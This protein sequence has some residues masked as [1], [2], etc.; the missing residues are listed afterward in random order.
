MEILAWSVTWSELGNTLIT[1]S[2]LG[3]FAT[4]LRIKQ[5]NLEASN[6][7]NSFQDLVSHSIRIGE[8]RDNLADHCIAAWQTGLRSPAQN[9]QMFMIYSL[10]TTNNSPNPRG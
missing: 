7:P 10:Q 8:T 5:L 3:R 2:V 9:R 4:I 1:S 6:L